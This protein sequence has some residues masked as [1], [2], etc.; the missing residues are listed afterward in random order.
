MRNRVKV[1]RA[2]PVQSAGYQLSHN[3]STTGAVTVLVDTTRTYSG[4]HIVKETNDIV[5]P[6]Y[7][8]RSAQGEII[9]NPFDTYEYDFDGPGVFM[10]NIHTENDYPVVHQG[11]PYRYIIDAV[12]A[13]N[14][15][16]PSPYC[17][18]N[19]PA[20]TEGML[21]T[22]K[23]LAVT[24]AF[25]NVNEAEMQAL[26]TIAESRKSIDFL[27]T[28]LRRAYR[29]FK[30]IRKFDANAIKR[31]LKPKEIEEAYMQF[32]YALRP[33]IY[34]VM[35]LTAALNKKRAANVRQ[36]SRGYAIDF[37]EGAEVFTGPY[38]LPG[39]CIV[40][41]YTLNWSYKVSARAGVL[42]DV[43]VTSDTTFGL[44][45]VLEA[46]WEVLPFS[47]IA[48]WFANIGETIAA[49]TPNMRAE[50]LASWV[51]TREIFE[52]SVSVG[53]VIDNEG[54]DHHRVVKNISVT[55]PTYTG[56][57]LVL[58][59]ETDPQLEV[60]PT[61][62]MRL[63]AFKILDLAIVIRSLMGLRH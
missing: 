12:G 58:R 1:T 34:D 37:E 7:R 39:W 4:R 31:Q 40:E 45:D 63:D 55:K 2:D 8:R 24:S 20:A 30:A 23:D 44:T 26:A 15:N 57:E 5:T 19:P 25:A 61:A 43:D 60:F 16:G 21:D 29:L 22:V 9:N 52:C 48:D 42:C 49:W 62:E 27:Y 35:D 46:G 18:A 33:L 53:N 59:R 51:T 56:K 13:W 38:P 10:V 50:Q 28:T 3:D 32:R 47:F 36:T 54:E 6:D 14:Y 41:D 11:A 17:L